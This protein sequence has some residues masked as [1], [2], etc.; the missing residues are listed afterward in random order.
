M[1]KVYALANQLKYHDA[2]YQSGE[3]EL[4]EMGDPEWLLALQG[5]LVDMQVRMGSKVRSG[6]QRSG[7]G[8]IGEERGLRS[9]EGGGGQRHGSVNHIRSWLY[10]CVCANVRYCLW[11]RPPVSGGDYH[12]YLCMG[13]GQGIIRRKKC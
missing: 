4:A 5:V 11:L 2:H 12:C 13:I 9:G 8:V 7:Q 10:F 6:G 3:G 1:T